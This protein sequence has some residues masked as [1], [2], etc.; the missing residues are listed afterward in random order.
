LSKTNLLMENKSEILFNVMKVFAW[1]AFIGLSIEVGSII[2]SFVFSLIFYKP[3]DLGDL[4][5]KSQIHY[6]GF[7]IL[8]IIIYGLK[9][10]LAYLLI[11]IFD[12]LVLINPFQEKVVN[13]ISKLGD[14][15]LYTGLTAIFT[16]LY[17]T[18]YLNKMYDIAIPIRFEVS[19]FFFL[20]G[21]IFVLSKIFKRGVEIQS[22]NELTV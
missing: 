5:S 22:E 11:R 19:E 7:C 3:I 2:F 9:A 10:H 20:A 14:T 1:I 21:I 8:V 17:A 6:N 16:N 15:A 12:A 18:Q 4:Y 13:L